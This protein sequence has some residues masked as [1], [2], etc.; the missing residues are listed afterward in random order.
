MKRWILLL[1]IVLSALV[2][3]A[4]N[5]EPQPEENAAVAS[6]IPT[7]P[8]VVETATALPPT[9]QPT[10]QQPT[11]QPTALPTEEPE[12]ETAVIAGRTDEGAFFLGDPAAPVTI[13][14]YS[15]FL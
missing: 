2:A 8:P 9:T 12:M 5:A 15:D 3:C 6:P 10:A 14:D 7:E 13:I 11:A 4:P 1:P